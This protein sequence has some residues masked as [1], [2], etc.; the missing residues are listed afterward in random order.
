[1]KRSSLSLFFGLLMAILITA[2]NARAYT[3]LDYSYAEIYATHGLVTQEGVAD[4]G[5]YGGYSSVEDEG[6][7]PIFFAHGYRWWT[8]PSG[9]DIWVCRY[10]VTFDFPGSHFCQNDSDLGCMDGPTGG[11]ASWGGIIVDQEEGKISSL[12][13]ATNDD[14]GPTAQYC[15]DNP[16]GT[17]P[18]C[19][20][21]PST[22]GYGSAYGYIRKVVSVE[23]DGTLQP[24]DPVEIEA[25]LS[26]QGDGVQ[27][28]SHV[29]PV[30]FLTRMGD[31][32]WH[33]WGEYL[34][35]GGVEDVLGTPDMVDS[36]L[37]Y[38]DLSVIPVD[39]TDYTNSI[40]ASVSV[41][42][43]IVMET[44][45]RAYSSLDNPGSDG[46]N[47]ET[48][49]GSEP[50]DLKTHLSNATTEH[51][52]E[53]VQQNGNTVQSF[54]TAT[55]QGAVLVP[56]ISAGDKPDITVT[57]AI[58][59][60]DDLQVP[61]GD[62]TELSSSEA[63]VTVT[64]DGTAYLVVGNIDT[65]VPPF[66]IVNDNCSA[67]T[68][69]P[70][71]SRTFTVRFEPTAT[72]EFED[73]FD[74]PSNDPD[75]NPVT[76]AVN[77]TGTAAPVPDI[78]VTDS[79]DPADDLDISFGDIYVTPGSS[80]DATVTVTNDGTADLIIDTVATANPLAPPFSIVNDNCS[81]QTIAPGE[82]RT[83]TVR[84]E[85]TATG[86]FEDSFDI[87]SNDPDENP[88]IVSVGGT[89]S[90]DSDGV[91]DE[92]EEGPDGTDPNYDGNNDGT[93]D[94]Q[95]DNVVSCHTHDGQNYVTLAVPDTASLNDVS[96]VDNPSP[97]D[98]PSGL[99]F[100][101]GFFDFTVNNV[102]AG[103]ATT[104]TLYLPDGAPPI[105]YYKYGPTPTNQSDHWYE[106]LYDGETGAEI[107]GNVIT[108]HFVD[109]KR[110]DDI[111][112][113]DGS[114]IDQGG[115][116][117]TTIPTPTPAPSVDDGGGGCFI[118]LIKGN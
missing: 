105:T 41:G 109:A 73:S 1:M 23:S 37:G 84:F 16:F 78:T 20:G 83:F 62:V 85:P 66:S 59:P 31:A 50:V 112:T 54:I 82:S 98:A 72:G 114:I 5:A 15:V 113:Q 63:I 74:I 36:M 4:P 47:E 34:N 70:G 52:K 81:A 8:Y 80:S 71:E 108:L 60:N 111:L 75:E 30:L 42:D 87:P 118:S 110:G 44:M 17:G 11:K 56:Y 64:N 35:W 106:F 117:F 96:A 40:S 26:L 104:V 51:V 99:E 33:T 91:L 9:C 53:F 58:A 55:T 49:A 19:Y 76:V 27:S 101:Y 95:Q 107:N 14:D 77:G 3:N 97:G 32:E 39:P 43:V 29:R 103:G 86:E 79:V 45:F 93:P 100:P 48:W 57:D 69:A 38:M 89:G 12:V 61:F 10:Y 102:G 65:P 115:P 24:G 46:Q 94:S 68:I 25:S 88:V 67:Q 22:W 2:G 13:G 6:T 7:A 116:G 90:S 92:E 18:I 28:G 21:I